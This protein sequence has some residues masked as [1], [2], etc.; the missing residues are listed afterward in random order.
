MLRDAFERMIKNNVYPTGK[1]DFKKR[2]AVLYGVGELSEDDYMYLIK[3]LNPSEVAEVTPV[4]LTPNKAT[5]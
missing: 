5:I 1:E 2:M 3:L 4:E